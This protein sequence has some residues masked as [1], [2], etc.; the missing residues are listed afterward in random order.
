MPYETDRVD[1][2][3][4]SSGD[5]VITTDLQFS[6]GVQGVRQAIQIKLNNFQGEWFADLNNGI[7]Y[8]QRILGKRFNEADIINIFRGA[9]LSVDGVLKVLKIAASY[10]GAT[11]I[12]TV[13]WEVLT[14][15]DDVVSDSLP[16]EV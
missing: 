4:D 10:V 12:A 15:F 8:F 9:L 2:L 1:L 5:V 14:E 13:T 11:R 6:S 16:I 7:P 3:L